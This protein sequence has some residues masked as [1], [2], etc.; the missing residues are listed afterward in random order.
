MT[1]FPTAQGCLKSFPHSTAGHLSEAGGQWLINQ[2]QRSSV[3]KT[4]IFAAVKWR[5]RGV[6][7]RV[8]GVQ[9]SWLLKL[10]LV[11]VKATILYV[12]TWFH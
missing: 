10:A 4:F 12:L 5:R 8:Q 1:P 6:K 9:P 2:T 3:C 7:G 11:T